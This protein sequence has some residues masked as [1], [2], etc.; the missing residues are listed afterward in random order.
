V[1]GLG[2]KTV[3]ALRAGVRTVLV[4]ADNAKDIHELP[5]FV[6]AAL[7]IVPVAD[8]DQVMERTLRAPARAAAR[9]R[10][11]SRP[12]DGAGRAPVGTTH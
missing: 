3:A 11:R 4:P 8:M 1:G 12:R 5:A 9:P 7:D 10:P 2:E 6:R